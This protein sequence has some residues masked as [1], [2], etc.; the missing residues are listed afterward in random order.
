MVLAAFGPHSS[1][2][3][4]DD[5]RREWLARRGGD[6]GIEMR[7]RHP[8]TRRITLALDGAVTASAFGSYEIDARVAGPRSPAA[9]PSIGTIARHRRPGS[10]MAMSATGFMLPPGWCPRK[11]AHGGP[12]GQVAGPGLPLLDV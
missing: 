2:V 6:K 8:R 7:L 3:S 12:E 9:F 4:T 11:R 10:F 1:P 5:A